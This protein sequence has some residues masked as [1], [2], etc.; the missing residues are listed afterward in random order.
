MHLLMHLL[1]LPLVAGVSYE[2][3]KGLAHS[4]S[5]AAKILR[6]P[7]LQLQ[8]L[9]TRQPDDSMLECAIS[10]M[11]AALYGLPEHAPRTPEGWAVLKT[12]A[13]SDPDYTPPKD[14]TVSGL[15]SWL[16]PEQDT[17]SESTPA[18]QADSESNG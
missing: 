15:F 3:L 12:Y 10:A 17:G 6:W 8:R 11:N 5:K 16:E 18:E 4:E 13:E 7:G 2:V 1:M 14:E 9:T